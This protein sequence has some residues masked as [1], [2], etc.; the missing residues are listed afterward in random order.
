VTFAASAKMPPRPAHSAT[1]SQL[2]YQH[3][4]HNSSDDMEHAKM[5]PLSLRRSNTYPGRTYDTSSTAGTP[6]DSVTL[7]QSHSDVPVHRLD[8]FGFIL[9]MDD[10]GNVVSDM[11]DDDHVH[12]RDAQL[13]PT[14]AAEQQRLRR[15]NKWNAMLKQTNWSRS[16]RTLK[17]RLRKGVPDEQR[18]QVWIRLGQIARQSHQ[19]ARE[20]GLYQELVQASVEGHLKN[21]VRSKSFK[22]IQDTIERDIHRTYPRHCLF[23]DDQ[24]DSSTS[25]SP[26][27]TTLT[28]E[29]T[30][31]GGGIT[32][33]ALE[34]FCGSQEISRLVMRMDLPPSSH[35]GLNHP[36]DVASDQVLHA[37]GGQASLRRVLK[38]YSLY[39]REIG[40]CQGMN[41]IAGMFLTLMSEEEAFWLLVGKSYLFRSL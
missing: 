39:D 1:K 36:D 32:S 35:A 28:M 21:I 3:Q 2:V 12:E 27:P 33:T 9:N 20:P 37:Q 41:F 26:T 25:G 15:V 34:A 24:D 18:G 17:R 4:R 5:S 40:Y 7:R 29:S 8:K 31:D 22:S 11:Y 30:E 38:A 6:V 14:F 13:P 19:R 23:F 10:R 16:N